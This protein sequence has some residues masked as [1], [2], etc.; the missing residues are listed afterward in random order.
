MEAPTSGFDAE[1]VAAAHHRNTLQR[2]VQNR[3]MR[4]KARLLHDWTT[5]GGSEDDFEEVWPSIRAQLGQ[6]RVME[7]GDKARARSLTAFNRR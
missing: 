6:I 5:A 2:N 3:I 7:I 1:R 4:E